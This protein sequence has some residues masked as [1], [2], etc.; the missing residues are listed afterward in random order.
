MSTHAPGY[1]STHARKHTTL[2]CTGALVRSYPGVVFQTTR[3]QGYMGTL[4]YKD[5]I[6]EHLGLYRE[7]ERE[8]ALE[9]NVTNQ[10]ELHMIMHIPL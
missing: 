3:V 8:R 7:R 9:R 1:T 6:F 4:Q 2:R 5:N 10:Y